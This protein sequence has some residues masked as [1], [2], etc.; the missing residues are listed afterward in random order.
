MP[1]QPDLREFQQEVIDRMQTKEHAD[2]Q[3]STL[4]VQIAGQNWLVDMLDISGVLPL[5]PPTPVPLTKPWFLGVVNVRGV[6]Y[7]VT[8]MAAYQQKGKATSSFATSGGSGR[9]TSTGS[10]RASG[11]AANR[12]LLVT[13]RHAFNAAL[14]VDRVLG[15]RNARAWAQDE[16]QGQIQYRDE[17]GNVWHKLDVAALLAQ[18]DFLQVG[19]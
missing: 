15:L 7:G 6:L 14:L 10:G 2:D 19:V 12:I 5:P 17:R 9:A 8:D 18:P 4:G 11:T 3:A 1:K 16:V 13:E